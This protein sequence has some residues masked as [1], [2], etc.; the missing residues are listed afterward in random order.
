MEQV[1]N[2]FKQLIKLLFSFRVYIERIPV[3]IMY[4]NMI[5]YPIFFYLLNKYCLFDIIDMKSSDKGK[6]YIII[7]SISEYID[8][9]FLPNSFL[10]IEHI[11]RQICQNNLVIIFIF[12][13][14]YFNFKRLAKG[15]TL[16]L[17]SLFIIE[18]YYI[19][20]ENCTDIYYLCSLIII[21]LTFAV[22][23]LAKITR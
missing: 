5:M 9:R 3:L 13:I 16:C 11:I 12:W 4:V 7:V 15:A 17:T 1:T 10:Y 19:L 20:T 8:M 21:W 22:V 2:R 18:T 23:T 14:H 6:E